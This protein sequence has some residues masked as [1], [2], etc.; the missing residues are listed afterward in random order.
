MGLTLYLL[1]RSEIGITAKFYG[2]LD[3]KRKKALGSSIGSAIGIGSG[4]S[5]T[6]KKVC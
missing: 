3:M 4:G 6:S 2:H 1:H 5:D